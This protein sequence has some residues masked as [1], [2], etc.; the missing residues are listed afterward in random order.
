MQNQSTQQTQSKN[1]QMATQLRKQGLP[2]IVK[3]GKVIITNQSK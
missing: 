1:E 3:D 2:V